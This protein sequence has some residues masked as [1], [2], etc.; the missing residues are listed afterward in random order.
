MDNFD[1]IKSLTQE[2]E[3][4]HLFTFQTPIFTALKKNKKM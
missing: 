4:L 1:I 2:N 3:V